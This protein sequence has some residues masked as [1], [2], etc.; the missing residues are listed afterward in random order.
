MPAVA[1]LA[2]RYERDEERVDNRVL[3][4][5]QQRTQERVRRD[6]LERKRQRPPVVRLAVPFVPDAVHATSMQS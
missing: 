6:W 2:E 1:A 5:H 4:R 3:A